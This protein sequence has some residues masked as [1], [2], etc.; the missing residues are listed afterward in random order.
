MKKE[1]KKKVLT[2]V[3]QK[4]FLSRIYLNVYCEEEKDCTYFGKM[5]L[6]DLH[7]SIPLEIEFTNETITFW[8]WNGLSME[9]KQ[10]GEKMRNY[11][12]GFTTAFFKDAYVYVDDDAMTDGKMTLLLNF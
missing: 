2:I 5:S 11:L 6:N 9:G 10:L 8:W 12:L 7:A 3:D 4:A 1:E